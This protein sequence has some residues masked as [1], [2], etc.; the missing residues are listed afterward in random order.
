MSVLT[1]SDF[2]TLDRLHMPFGSS[3]PV[4]HREMLAA[5]RLAAAGLL[6]LRDRARAAGD[7]QSSLTI[8]D[9]TQAGRVA[10][11]TWCQAMA[12]PPA[13]PRPV[14]LSPPRRAGLTPRQRQLLDFITDYIDCEGCSPSYDEMQAH[15]GLKSKSGITRLVNGLAWRGWVTQQKHQYRSVRPIEQ[16]IEALERR[17]S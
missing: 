1:N 2:A 11:H 12:L 6:R 14:T 4:L 13:A 7:T 5:K 17:A 16:P 15:L 3:T 8:A 10:L 9:L